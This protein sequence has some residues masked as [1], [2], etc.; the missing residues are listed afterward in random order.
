MT[1][2]IS[3]LSGK[4]GVG[5][6][7]VTANLGILL[8]D[9][10]KDITIID[11]NLTTP[12][13]GLH[14]GIPLFPKTL[15][16]VLKNKAKISDALYEHESGLKIIPAG[17]SLNDLR[18]IDARDLPSALLGLLGNTGLVIIDSAAGLGREALAAIE[19]SNE[20][21]IV[22]NPDL[23]AVLDAMKA[24]K[25]S[26]KIGTKVLGLVVNRISNKRHE[27]SEREITELTEIPILAKIP[28]DRSV[29]KSIAMKTPITKYKP[30][31]K[32][33]IELKKLASALIGRRIEYSV[34]W[35]RRV[36]SIFR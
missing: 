9:L 36:F 28:E 20:A 35:Y 23:P 30:N 17:I 21:I 8:A 26:E 25:L 2:V 12:N 33:S 34:P 1:R 10:G 19:S 7:F 24:T 11:G 27:L 6:T 15:H 32:V 29:S 4:G 22:T 3:I 14:L 5:K 16:D 13:L 31:S 18:G